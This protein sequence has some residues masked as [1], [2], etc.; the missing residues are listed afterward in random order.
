MAEVKRYCREQIICLLAQGETSSKKI[1][2]AVGCGDAYVHKIRSK[3]EAWGNLIRK[4]EA[5]RAAE[6]LGEKLPEVMKEIEERVKTPVEPE[7]P[8]MLP[9]PGIRTPYNTVNKMKR[10]YIS[11]Y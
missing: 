4:T 9:P 1:K 8:P 11:H 6:T 10:I 3:W 7:R 2:M 5:L